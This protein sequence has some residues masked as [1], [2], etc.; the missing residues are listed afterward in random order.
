VSA[1]AYCR[2]AQQRSDAPPSSYI[3]NYKPGDM[4]HAK[5]GRDEL[6]GE[7]MSKINPTHVRGA[8]E[9][10]R[11]DMFEQP[12]IGEQDVPG[13]YLA[14][15]PIVGDYA[16][17][18]STEPSQ[19]DHVN[20]LMHQ[21]NTAQY[22]N[23]HSSLSHKPAPPMP[24]A[25]LNSLETAGAARNSSDHVSAL[26]HQDGA[27]QYQQYHSSLSQKPAPHLQS[28]LGGHAAPGAQHNHVDHVDALL[29]E[30]GTEQYQQ[31][32]S[33]LSHRPAASVRSDGSHA[34]RHR[35]QQDQVS[36]VL[37][38]GMG[39]GPVRSEAQ[40]RAAKSRFPF[41]YSQPDED[42]G[43]LLDCCPP[44]WHAHIC[45]RCYVGSLMH[46]CCTRTTSYLRVYSCALPRRAVWSTRWP[47]Y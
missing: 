13:H 39:R 2:L 8:G 1:E 15:N 35:A 40:L 33:S 38:H 22:Q 42:A 29:H 32:H 24:E 18:A 14:I 43:A 5:G 34:G 9:E 47:R 41:A 7:H 37:D 6:A 23:Y 19:V 44:V 46:M 20:A 16:G 12:F 30:R 10:F 28:S 26:M 17:G 4:F 11:P 3:D 21:R 25:T 45:C 31:Y 36:S 27:D